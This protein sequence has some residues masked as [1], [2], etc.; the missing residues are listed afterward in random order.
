MGTSSGPFSTNC[1][2]SLLDALQIYFPS[3]QLGISRLAV[4]SVEFKQTQVWS[5]TMSKRFYMHKEY[6]LLCALFV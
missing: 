1:L 4:L 3:P 6:I 5:G 2:F